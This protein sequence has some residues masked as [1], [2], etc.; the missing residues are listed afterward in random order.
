MSHTVSLKMDWNMYDCLQ[1][2]V[3]S[4]RDEIDDGK[5][6]FDGEH[7]D[8]LLDGLSRLEQAVEIAGQELK[9]DA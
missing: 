2:A 7:E 3:S 1:L 5:L 6:S 4:L 9:A 8:D